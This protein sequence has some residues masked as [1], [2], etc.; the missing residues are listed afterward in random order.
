M[1]A[2]T[3]NREEKTLSPLPLIA[4]IGV[5]GAFQPALALDRP[6][7]GPDY[8]EVARNWSPAGPAGSGY[9]AT[10]NGGVSIFFNTSAEPEFT[11]GEVGSEG[12]LTVT[13]PVIW[14]GGDFTGSGVPQF[15]G[16]LYI[17]G[18]SIK[19]TESGK[20]IGVR[21]T[22]LRSNSTAPHAAATAVPELGRWAL[23]LAGL[24]LMGAMVRRHHCFPRKDLD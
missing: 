18:N 13:G 12:Y 22:T 1:K 15:A 24:C 11:A 23:L 10:I 6:G 17:S 16:P 8:W 2:G 3:N 20:V 9:G 14:R 19:G 4:V 5:L 7:I 21:N